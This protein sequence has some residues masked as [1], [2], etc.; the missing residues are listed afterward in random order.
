M[1][2]CCRL[3]QMLRCRTG[4]WGAA[5]FP[6]VGSVRAAGKRPMG[7][8]EMFTDTKAAVPGSNFV[9]STWS[10]FDAVSAAVR[11]L[12]RPS[13]RP[14]NGHRHMRALSLALL[15]SVC[16][17]VSRCRCVCLSLSPSRA[18]SRAFFLPLSLPRAP[19]RALALLV[20]LPQ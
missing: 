20:S 19:S 15:L 13:P 14:T 7:W 3:I 6:Q 5:A 12:T 10:K 9:L 4:C 1:G 11:E 8:E 16:L 18:L 17:S 2:G